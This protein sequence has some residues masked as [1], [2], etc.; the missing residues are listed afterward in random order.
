MA[1]FGEETFPLPIFG[2]LGITDRPTDQL[3]PQLTNLFLSA[4]NEYRVRED[5]VLIQSTTRN[6][7]PI[8][9]TTGIP[10]S[11]YEPTHE[12]FT[13]VGSESANTPTILQFCDD[14]T[15]RDVK[16]LN[17]NSTT[18]SSVTQ[19]IAAGYG[20]KAF[21]QYK[22]HF[23]ASNGVVGVGGKIYQLSNFNTGGGALTV[24][25]LTG[26][27]TNIGVDILLTFRSR[28]F[29]IKKN[30]IYYTDLPSI[31]GYP[32]TWNVN[33]NFIDIPSVDY[34]VTVHNAFIFRDKI[35]MF[36]DKGIYVLAVN[37]AP[38]NWSIQPVSANFPI[39]DR[40]SVCLNKNV[41]FLTDQSSVVT[42]DG[43]AFK[44]VS[45]NIRAVFHN[46][47]STFCWF[48]IYPWEDG[49]LLAR[50]S[51]NTS[52]GF[53]TRSTTANT[54][55]KLLYFNM[56]MWT[57]LEFF[58]AFPE[59]IKAGRSLL[60]YRGKI[61]SSWICGGNITNQFVF[62]YDSGYWKGDCA[63]STDHVGGTRSTKPVFLTTP[64]PFLKARTFRKYKYVDIYAFLNDVNTSP[65]LQFNGETVL[66]SD[67][68][69]S[70]WKAPIDSTL[71][72]Q[73]KGLPTAPLSISGLIDVNL[74]GLPNDPPFLIFGVD[75]VYNQDNRGRDGMGT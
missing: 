35:Y 7:V 36:T 10:R 45:G 25:D 73:F 58:D 51:F 5:F 63:N 50:N 75:I 68:G 71:G 3:C 21:C 18:P 30:R 6:N 48:S 12:V 38:V 13:A 29:G 65:N 59:V 26:A 57:E 56:I 42:F 60:P 27:T 14:G 69:K 41:V 62:F 17:C 37:G 64:A 11:L 9:T 44:T 61:A 20:V 47:P 1:V 39:Y 19:T 54:N 28:V 24:T 34:D 70:I 40:D 16:W 49:A 8:A 46:N 67:K 53:Y 31:G 22:D 52:G 2:G 32:E 23:Y 66:A 55:R 72:S 33:I 15:T 43:T 4:E 74:S